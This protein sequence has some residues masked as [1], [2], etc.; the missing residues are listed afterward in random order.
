MKR[1][2]I[3]AV[4]A[5]CSLAGNGQDARCPSARLFLWVELIGFDNTKPDYGVGD[6]L[7]RMVRKPDVVSLMLDDDRLFRT[8]K[9]YSPDEKLLPGNCAYGAR[10]YNSERRRQDWTMGELKGL[11]AT[12]QKNG[13]QAFASFFCWY[14]VMPKADA[15]ME[16]IA[17]CLSAFI[18]DLG[19]DGF[20]GADGYAPPRYLM[21]SCADA[22]RA[23]LA[24]ERAERYAANWRTLAAALKAK[25]RKVWI[26]TCWTLDPFEA[27]YRYGVDYRL[28]A[29]TGIDGFIVESSAAA[30][31]MLGWNFTKAPA[32]DKSTAM[33]LRLKAAVPDMPLV[34][35]HG[36]NDGNEQWSAL[37]HTPSLTRSEALALGT[38]FRGNS[39]I[40]E[41][42]LACLAD[43]IRAEEWRELDK[44][45]TLPFVEA[46]G[47]LGARVVWS[48][49]AFDREFDDCVLSHDAS[50][51]TLLYE[52]LA[53]G[54]PL[55]GIVSVQ[56]A[57]ADSSY[58]I[59]LLNPEFFPK[60]ELAALRDRKTRVNEIGRG[61]RSRSPVAYIKR[62][63]ESQ[64]PGMPETDSCYWKRPLS[65]NRPPEVFFRHEAEAIQESMP[66][67]CREPNIHF[68][69]FRLANGRLAAFVRN[70]GDVYGDVLIRLKECVS[71]VLVHTDFPSLPV[72]TCLSGRIAPRDTMFISIGEHEWPMPDPALDSARCK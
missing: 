28:L 37:R 52:L 8:Y 4:C 16:G 24:R 62:K 70:E 39:R 25:G 13:V 22:D 21:P 65:E 59:V 2:L 5:F 49:A 29:K 26:N 20:H 46:K 27:L 38:L 43:G 72:K 47:P 33:L 68:W 69:G 15:E 51:Y 64:F 44:A 54:A 34:L 63:D 48:D 36:I 58:P 61:A 66:F 55:S 32:I 12:L 6:Y 3:A 41:G 23:R 11:V 71:D 30:R 10:P 50:S 67:V 19:F 14:D 9:G 7:G 57:L 45:W 18:G 56:E 53:H 42:Y 40:L 1:M 35:L 31:E 60:E 17:H